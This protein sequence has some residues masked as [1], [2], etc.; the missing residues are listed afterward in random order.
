VPK[1]KEREEAVERAMGQKQHNSLLRE[2]ALKKTRVKSLNDEIG[3]RVAEAVENGHLHKGAFGLMVRINAMEE[4][5]RNDFLRSFDL[6]REHVETDAT[7]G[8]G[9]DRHVGDLLESAEAPID[10]GA[11]RV[12]DN[13][14]LL[15]NGIKQLEESEENIE[16]EGKF[17]GRVH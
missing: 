6:Y 7:M 15:N 2:V 16:P 13:V 4:E 12:A 3:Q 5:K 11:A 14:A 8:W 10:N 1:A 9:G 17:T